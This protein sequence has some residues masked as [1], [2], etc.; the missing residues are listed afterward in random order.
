MIKLL[1]L[2]ENL[3]NIFINGD[4][5]IA[6]GD[7]SII[8][9]DNE[10][11]IS[12]ATKIAD[13]HASVVVNGKS[14][15]NNSATTEEAVGA[16]VSINKEDTELGDVTKETSPMEEVNKG[17]TSINDTHYEGWFHGQHVDILPSQ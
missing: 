10:V 2:V 6:N 16:L 4:T 13:G 14:H 5:K 1:S 9:T 8:V 15:M 3:R 11:D 12:G 17:D 7:S